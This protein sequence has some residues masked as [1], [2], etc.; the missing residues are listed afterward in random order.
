MKSEKIANK[1]LLILAVI[2]FAIA[3]AESL[4]YYAE[5]SNYP[6][7]YLVMVLQNSIQ[8]FGFRTSISIQNVLKNLQDNA[9]IIQT[10]VGYA[11]S[12]VVLV[13]PLCTLTALYKV[14]EMLLKAHPS[15]F[16]FKDAENITIF[17]YNE[18]VKALL[19]KEARSKE[20]SKKRRIRIISK[21]KLPEADEKFLMENKAVFY[22]FDCLDASEDELKKFYKKIKLDKT[23]TVILYEK[24]S[25]KNFS[26]FY[27]MQKTKELLAK[28]VKF[29]CYYEENEIRHIMEDYYDGL[30]KK[31]DLELFSVSEL[32][33][34]K[35]FEEHS[36]HSYYENKNIPLEKQTVHM[37]ILGFGKLG[38]QLLLQAMNQAVLHSNN[39][40]IFDVMDVKIEEQKNLFANH[41][42]SSYMMM[43]ENEWKIPNRNADG[44][45]KI[46][47]HKIDAR[48]KNFGKALVEL[49]ENCPF[50][51]VTVCINDEKKSLHCMLEVEKFLQREK[52]EN[53]PIGIRMEYDEQMVDYLMQNKSTHKNVFIISDVKNAISLDDMLSEKINQEAKEY[54]ELYEQI[55]FICIPDLGN[56]SEVEKYPPTSWEYLKLYKRDSNRASGCH[57]KI[58]QE[59]LNQQKKSM[60]EIWE[61]YFS[62]GKL[63]WK[64]K[65]DLV[66]EG[67]EEA[68]LAKINE[69]EFLKEM[70]M[71]EHRRWCYYMASVGWRYRTGKKEEKLRETPYLIDWEGLCR[72]HPDMCKY[73]LQPFILSMNKWK[74]NKDSKMK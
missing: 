8:A 69:D 13:A 15:R 53:V 41:F 59:V 37:L 64:P 16:W 52:I 34:R 31:P 10:I 60:E 9:G 7:F 72:N 6:L 33:A 28:K 4:I 35:V 38:Q 24:V 11:Y 36:I 5:Y 2:S 19:Q 23:Q 68:F 1:I 54:H 18:N 17:G 73:D 20:E 32:R 66:F 49:S 42:S 44:I 50:T 70:A 3:M 67:T 57:S 51:Y 14:F 46:R 12:V 48:Y 61:Q 25:A 21:D 65:R 55:H 74:E 29:Y 40:I 62:E 56:L 47:F 63:L 43:N 30:T 45:L 58:E 71:M 27:M 39:D 22:C 26:L